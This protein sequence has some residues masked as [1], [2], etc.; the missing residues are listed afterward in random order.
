MAEVHA[1]AEVRLWDR[2]VGAVVEMDDGRVVFE[3]ADA[4][5]RSGLEISPL[6]LPLSRRGPI[7]FDELRR[8]PA[9][10]GLPGVLADALP[11]SFGNKVIRAYFAARGQ[12]ER[13]LRPVQRLLY[14]GERA[15]GALTFHPAESLPAE[16]LPLLDEHEAKGLIAR[17][18]SGV[19]S[20][21][22]P[23]AAAAE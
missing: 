8:H 12:A 16:D 14:V 5:R 19:L 18:H 13:A 6:N 10:E 21:R 4:F 23:P 11:D 9:F 7:V 3:Y 20:N 2:T 1:H 15:L 17:L 22:K